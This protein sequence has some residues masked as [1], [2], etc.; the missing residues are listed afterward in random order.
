M[1]TPLDDEE[2]QQLELAKTRL[3]VRD[4]EGLKAC[5]LGLGASIFT[6]KPWSTQGAAAL[7]IFE[8]ILQ[9]KDKS[10]F[11]YYATETMS[12]HRK[13]SSS[14]FSMPEVWL[15]PGAPARDHVTFELK[16]GSEPQESSGD[17]FKFFGVEPS[18]D[19]FDPMDA[20]AVVFSIGA[21]C[22][23]ADDAQTLEQLFVAACSSVELVCGLAGYQLHCSRY[24]SELAETHAVRSGM[25]YRGVDIPRALS[26]AHAVRTDGLKGVGWLTALG[27]PLLEEVGGIHALIK[28]LPT[29]VMVREIPTGAVIRI[30]AAPG[31]GDVN[32]ADSLSDARACAQALAAPLNRFIA[33]VSPF[34][35]DEI[36]SEV[37]DAWHGRL[38]DA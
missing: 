17:F 37:S 13:T 19:E 21:D 36:E 16:G 8:Q 15:K 32:R 7:T 5:A 29:A 27:K 26:D 33:R 6:G 10:R 23:G 38:L 28:A 18:S 25:R 24:E 31:L 12:K 1:S 30:G 14:T 22:I 34:N 9:W 20:T 11:K 3:E 2:K 4:D 35:I